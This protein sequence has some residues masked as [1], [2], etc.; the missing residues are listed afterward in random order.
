MFEDA[1]GPMG[2]FT[3]RFIEAVDEETAQMAAVDL[4]RQ[5]LK[6]ILGERLAGECNPSLSLDR[7]NEVE[8]LPE[9]APGSGFTWFPMSE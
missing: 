3:T 9:N 5:E 6:P 2:F 1:A 4:I 7:I 8:A